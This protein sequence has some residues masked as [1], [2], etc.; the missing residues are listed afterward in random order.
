[1]SAMSARVAII[2][3]KNVIGIEIPNSI[4]N[5]VYLSELFKHEEFVSNEK[6]LIL[7]L[8]KD[9]SGNA[10]FANLENMPHLLI[11]GTTGSGKSVGIN[12]MITSILYKHS[13]EDCKFI[14][15]DPKM[16]ELSVYEGVPTLLLLLADPKKAIIALKWVVREMEFRYKKMS[17]LGVRNIENYNQRIIEA[18]NKSEKIIRSIPSGINLKLDNRQQV[19]LKIKKCHS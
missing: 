15:I 6:N 14:L 3:G 1:M 16:L 7:A 5:P 11:A 17:L 9:I 10:R 8:G 18:I 12:V 13:P 2:P 19:R 4:K